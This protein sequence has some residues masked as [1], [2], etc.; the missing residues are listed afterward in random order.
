MLSDPHRL[1]GFVPLHIQF[2]DLYSYKVRIL[3][4]SVGWKTP[5]GTIT[6]EAVILAICALK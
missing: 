5:A 6:V 4:A 2:H 1:V 3:F